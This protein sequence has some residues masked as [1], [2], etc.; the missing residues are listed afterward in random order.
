MKKKKTT[1]TVAA[2]AAIRPELHSVL[3]RRGVPAAAL[4]LAMLALG[5]CDQQ[6]KQEQRPQRPRP[7]RQEQEAAKNLAVYNDLR[8]KQSWEL[9][10]SIGKDLVTRFPNSAQAATVNQTL[11]EDRGQGRR[12]PRNQAP[13]A[14]SGP[15]SPARS[16]AASRTPP[17]STATSPVPE[18]QRVRLVLRRHTS[19][20]ESAYL[21]SPGQGFECEKE[22]T[23]TVSIDGQEPE[24]LK[25]V[26]PETTDPAIL[27]DDHQGLHR[28][29][30]A[31]EQDQHPA[32]AEGQG[33]ADRGVRG[34]RIRPGQVPRADRLAAGPTR[35]FV[36]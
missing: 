32:Q 36:P 9:A 17:R 11:A 6:A 35:A 33:A 7:R 8:E 23:L 2:P 26:L 24:K 28:Q 29:A 10:S 30:R 3:R 21:V 14:S 34:R 13:W 31:G 12:D 1:T 19:W 25:A 27:I 4:L 18:D 5:A 16:R 22:C 20:G 15:T